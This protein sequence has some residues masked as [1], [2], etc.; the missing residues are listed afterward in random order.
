MKN[1]FIS[2]LLVFLGT[3][4]FAQKSNDIKASII[5][6]ASFSDD[7]KLTLSW[8]PKE[9]VDGYNLR[10]RTDLKDNWTTEVVGLVDTFYRFEQIW[11]GSVEVLVETNGGD[12]ANTYL[13]AANEYFLA[14]EEEKML[15]LVTDSIYD[16]LPDLI[17]KYRLILQKELISTEIIVVDGSNGSV[18]QIKDEIVSRYNSKPFEY[19]LI[20]GHVAVPYSGNT[21]IDGHTPDHMGAWVAD[22]YYGEVD[23]TWT[24]ETINNVDASREANQN[25]PGDGK[26]DQ[27]FF[28]SEVEIAVGRVDFSSLTKLHESEIELTRRYLQRNMDYRTGK[29][30]VNRRAVIDNNFN[31]P[32]GFAQGAI[33][34]FHTFLEPDSINYGEFK[35]CTEQNYLFT[36]GAGGGN[37]QG[38]GGIINTNQLVGDSIQSIFTT[39][40]GSYFGDWDVANNLLRAALARG[41]SLISAWSGRPIWYFHPMAMGENVG[42]IL[43]NAQN[44]HGNYYSQFGKQLTHT[45]LLGDPSLKM[46]YQ[47]S[48]EE[49]TI[50][51]DH[52]TWT[53]SSVGSEELGFTIYYKNEDQWELLGTGMRMENRLDFSEFPDPKPSKVLIR[54][55]R[56][57]KSRSGSYY[58]EGNGLMLELAISSSE[59]LSLQDYVY[60]NPAQD[61]IYLSNS[62]EKRRVQVF[63]SD[64]KLVLETKESSKINVSQLQPGIYTLNSSKGAQVFVKE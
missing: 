15:L 13:V 28:P 25:V 23:G 44:N 10:Y 55:V 41:S 50:E 20:L 6:Q 11:E 63:S 36:F 59:D 54:P 31:L 22:G 19:I 43:L 38:A 14:D 61:F 29:M 34:S 62:S 8:L 53:Y 9:G 27:S 2:C 39:I 3:F 52:V 57:I 32:E 46:D 5:T 16:A 60:P 35:Q 58:N 4:L 24:D 1:L 48:I 51:A 18:T 40:F 30:K 64:G 47:E 33:K 37:Y 42:Q 56:L 26:F 45:S 49:Y 12:F 17:E 7:N 21:A